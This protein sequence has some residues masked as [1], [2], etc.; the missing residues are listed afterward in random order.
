MSVKIYQLTRVGKS[1][2]RNP[3]L[4]E[5]DNAKIVQKLDFYGYATPEQL[6]DGEMD[7]N[8]VVVAL[9]RLKRNSPPI[10]EEK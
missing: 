10:V 1:L 4:S 6:V 5:S 2:A 7:Y 9:G 8:R 3:N